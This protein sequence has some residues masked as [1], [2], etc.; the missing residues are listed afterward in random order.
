MTID[1]TVLVDANTRSRES[2]TKSR[3]RSSLQV[4]TPDRL[5][6]AH[7]GVAAEWQV[8]VHKVHFV[9]SANW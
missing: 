8:V 3:A 9:M 6:D 4:F 5:P 2:E 7:K 1:T